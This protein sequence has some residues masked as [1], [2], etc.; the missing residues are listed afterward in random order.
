[1]LYRRQLVAT[2]HDEDAALVELDVVPL[3][4]SFGRVGERAAWRKKPCEEL[5]LLLQR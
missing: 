4:R 1:V 3:L 2:A 5:R